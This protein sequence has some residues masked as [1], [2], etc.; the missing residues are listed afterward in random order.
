MNI[1]NIATILIP[2][3]TFVVL[4][5]LN[6]H[7]NRRRVAKGEVSKQHKSFGGVVKAYICKIDIQQVALLA[8]SI[9]FLR[10]ANTGTNNNNDHYISSANR[11]KAKFSKLR[12]I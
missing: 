11:K 1:Y 8:T 10:A 9:L 2:V 3:I 4:V 5:G 6:I 7:Y 12:S